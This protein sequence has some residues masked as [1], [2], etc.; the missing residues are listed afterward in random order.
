[1]T[2]LRRLERILASNCGVDELF[3]QKN[4]PSSRPSIGGQRGR[5]MLVRLQTALGK[6][7]AVGPYVGD[8]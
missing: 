5:P 2:W 1:M 4:T 6:A 8:V 3:A 7:V